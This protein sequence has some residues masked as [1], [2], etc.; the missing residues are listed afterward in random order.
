[1]KDR[2]WRAVQAWVVPSRGVGAD[3]GA[4]AERAADGVRRFGH[5]RLFLLKPDNENALLAFREQ[6]MQKL[7]LEVLPVEPQPRESESSGAVENA[8][9]LFKGLL[10]VD[11]LALK[12]KM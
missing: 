3:D 10:R 12:R 5:R 1:M 8:V 11:I 9:K 7:S 4:A 2:R 6:A